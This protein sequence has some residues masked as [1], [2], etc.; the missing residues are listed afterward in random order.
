MGEYI[1]DDCKYRT[2]K[3]KVYHQTDTYGTLYSYGNIARVGCK[4]SKR[5]P[6]MM[7]EVPLGE[8]LDYRQKRGK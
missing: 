1:C 3:V 4:A 5:N 7:R 8:C 2:T 6:N